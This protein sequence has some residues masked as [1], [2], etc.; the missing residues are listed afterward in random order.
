MDV[1]IDQWFY[2]IIIW[3]MKFGFRMYIN[4]KKEVWDKGGVGVQNMKD[5]KQ[6]DN[7]C[8]GCNVGG[9]GVFFI[10]FYI[11]FFVVFKNYLK[12]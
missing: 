12:V 1:I 5:W 10:N 3:W 6:Y 7:F 8:V 11:V 9:N 2:F 4:G